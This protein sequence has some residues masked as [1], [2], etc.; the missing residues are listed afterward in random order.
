MHRRAIHRLLRPVWQSS[1]EAARAR[2]D[3]KVVVASTRRSTA[4]DDERQNG[5]VSIFGLETIPEDPLECTLQNSPSALGG[6]HPSEAG[7]RRT[8]LASPAVDGRSQIA[9]YGRYDGKAQKRNSSASFTAP[10]S[11]IAH[12]YVRFMNGFAGDGGDMTQLASALPSAFQYSH[13]D[14]VRR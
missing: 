7:P 5:V 12:S 13:S 14:Y 6:P 8:G 9:G 4:A 1:N 10:L 3:D 2:G 11:A